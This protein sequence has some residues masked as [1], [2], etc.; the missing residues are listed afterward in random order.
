MDLFSKKRLLKALAC[1]KHSCCDGPRPHHA[2]V[3]TESSSAMAQHQAHM[4]GIQ[5]GREG[6]VENELKLK[7]RYFNSAMC[8]SARFLQIWITRV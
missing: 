3:C 7:L 8:N 2:T 5:E 4:V 6:D 1:K